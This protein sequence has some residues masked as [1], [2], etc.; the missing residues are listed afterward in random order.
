MKKHGIFTKIFTYTI[1]SILLLLGVTVALFSQQ[2]KSFY[3]TIQT[4][5]IVASY[6]PLVNRIQRN[7]TSDI[8]GLAQRFSETN[9][10]FEFF[11]ADKDGVPIFATPNADT[12]GNFDGDFYYVVHKDKDYSIIAQ[13]RTGLESFYRDLIVR[14][15]TVFAIMLMLCLVCAFVFAREMTKPIKVLADNA[16]KMANL[17]DVPFPAER[18]DEIGA[19]ARDVHSMYVK[20]KN[21]ILREREL[22]ETQRYF[23]AAASHELKTP[24]AATSILL[25]GMLENIG[26]YK[27]HPK[28]LRECVK[29]MDTQS[30]VISEILEIVNLNDGKIVPVPEELNIRHTVAD[31]LPDFQ[32]LSE[33]NGQRIVTDIPDEQTCLADPKML[34]KALSNVIL[35][36]VQNTPEGGEIR[37][38]SEPAA[39]QYRLCVLNMG[40]RIDDTVLPK[41]FDPFYRVDKARSRKSG[42]NGLGLVIV[43]KTLEAMNVEFALENTPDGVLFWM[44]LPKM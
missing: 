19:L 12:S 28:Y 43:R 16:N 31:M 37:I 40:V 4:R 5:E 23:F 21:E 10:S 14:G 39:E 1:I 36:A 29:M 13:N 7:N 20:L 30:K 22:E 8:A 41:L 38:W 35:N 26:D 27:D 24:I 25:E 33:A 17:K 3:R 9:Q 42:R 34:Q 11:I 18:K 32:T 2:F 44:S 6:Q 15:V